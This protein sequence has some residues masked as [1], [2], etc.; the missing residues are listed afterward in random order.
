MFDSFKTRQRLAE[1]E[2]G[3][4]KL[5]RQFQSLDVEWMDTL[6]KLRTMMGRIVKD[7]ARAESAKAAIT[8]PEPEVEPG[9]VEGPRLTPKQ[10]LIQEQ[11]MAR[12]SR[13][14]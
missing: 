10:R 5:R 12:R 6:D 14:Q 1:L 4:E 8:P 2:E 13:M 7:R 11:I 9:N 3:L